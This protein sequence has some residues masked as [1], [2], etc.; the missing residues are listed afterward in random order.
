VDPSTWLQQDAEARGEALAA[1][2]HSHPEGPARFSDE[3]RRQAA[4]DG[5]PLFPGMAHLV[6][7]FRAGV[8]ATAVWAL[9]KA[10]GFDEVPC[11]FR[12]GNRSEFQVLDA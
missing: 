12:G 11:P 3:D 4:P 7:A 8:P 2:V 10:G 6:V 5:I 9:W 1:L